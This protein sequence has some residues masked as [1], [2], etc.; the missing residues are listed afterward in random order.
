MVKAIQLQYPLRFY[1]SCL[2]N[3]EKKERFTSVCPLG[4]LRVAVIYLTLTTLKPKSSRPLD[5][6][7]AGMSGGM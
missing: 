6:S 5:I 3:K 2:G 7:S 4:V 1:D